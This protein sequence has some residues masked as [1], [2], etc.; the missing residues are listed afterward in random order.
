MWVGGLK[1]LGEGGVGAEETGEKKGGGE[2]NMEASKVGREGEE[3]N[4]SGI[5]EEE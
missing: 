4:G 1:R 2:I 5:G 3:W